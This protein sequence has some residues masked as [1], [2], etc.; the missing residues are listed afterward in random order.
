[1]KVASVG[2]NRQNKIDFVPL[3]QQGRLKYYD[4]ID[5]ILYSLYLI[6]TFSGNISNT[7][8]SLDHPA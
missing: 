6:S 8:G 1:M 7:D 5:I 2:R 3:S 4:I